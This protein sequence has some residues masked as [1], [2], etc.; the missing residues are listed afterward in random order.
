MAEEKTEAQ[1]EKSLVE[2]VTE[3]FDLVNKYVREQIRTTLRKSL[4]LPLQRLGLNLGFTIVAATMIAI[5]VIFLAVGFFLYLAGAVGYP[6]AYLIIGFFYLV[7]GA[8][9]IALR[10]RTV[11]K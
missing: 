3:L 9:L 6:L 4:I 5:S 8:V 11:Q 7:I 2:L 10:A 1:P